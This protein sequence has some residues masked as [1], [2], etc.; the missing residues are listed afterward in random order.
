MSVTAIAVKSLREPVEGLEARYTQSL[1]LIE[2]LHRL[3]L[4][5]IKIELDGLEVQNL[6]SVQTLLLNNIGECELTIGELRSRGY[7]LGSNVSYNVRKL[8]DLGYIDYQRS[9]SDRRSVHIRLTEKGRRASEIVDALYQRQLGSL[10][11]V[12]N[13]SSGDLEQVNSTLMR[14]ESFWVNQIRFRL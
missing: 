6:N 5:V 9:K 10:D 13:L 11:V 1:R 8:V 7:Y 2:R 12:G 3:M 4:D 14:L